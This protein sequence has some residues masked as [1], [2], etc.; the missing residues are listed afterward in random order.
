[1]K[2]DSEISQEFSIDYLRENNLIET[3]QISYNS[4][5]DYNVESIRNGFNNFVFGE[6]DSMNQEFV[7]EPFFQIIQ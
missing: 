6:E 3:N 2:F 5:T 7:I 1:M 4:Q